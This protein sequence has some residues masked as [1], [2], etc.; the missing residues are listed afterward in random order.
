[1]LDQ[2]EDSLF[3][4]LVKITFLQQYF[5][6]Q[7]FGKIIENALA[8]ETLTQLKSLNQQKHVSSKEL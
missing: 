8:A 6:N 7:K 2:K 5:G 3:V 1:M 4:S